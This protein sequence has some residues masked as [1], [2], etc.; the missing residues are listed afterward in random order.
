[1]D[2]MKAIAIIHIKPFTHGGNL[3]KMLCALFVFAAAGFLAEGKIFAQES[4]QKKIDQA[5]PGSTVIIKSGIYNEP[6]TISKPLVIKGEGRIIFSSQSDESFITVEHTS[7]VVIN[8]LSVEAEQDR[9]EM[10]AIT[11]KDSSGIE[12]SNIEITRF[13]QG[14]ELFNVKDS[15]LD[16]LSIKGVRGHFSKKGNGISL[17]GTEGITV[18]DSEIDQVQDG[19]YIEEDEKSRVLDN[20]VTGSRYGIHLMYSKGVTAAGNTLKKNVTGLML[21]MT[22]Q[23]AIRDNRILLHTDYNGYGLVLFE[24]EAIVVKGNEISENAAGMSLQK[25]KN[26]EIVDNKIMANQTGVQF[27]HYDESNQMSGNELYGN[28]LSAASDVRGAG[29]DGNEWDDYRGFDLDRDGFGDTPHQVKDLF[30]QLMINEKPYQ[31]FFEAPSIVALTSLEK[32]LQVEEETGVRDERPV[33]NPAEDKEQGSFHFV[34]FLAGAAIFT[35]GV[36]GWR[37]IASS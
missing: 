16:M 28:I 19:L 11:V 1:M 18:R 27:I 31:F 34:F 30:S 5:E 26:S 21:M 25:I 9:N 23:T 14:V 8:H 10:T 33:V 32:K 17:F 35:G 37:K 6:I 7:H 12:L 3:K 2:M 36:L 29:V 13:N 24:G 22:N 15:T 4:L 20:L